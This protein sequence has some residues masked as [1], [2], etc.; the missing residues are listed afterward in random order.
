MVPIRGLFETHLIGH[1][2]EEGN[3]R[4][5]V[6][7]E[8][9]CH[10]DSSKVADDYVVAELVVVRVSDLDNAVDVGLCGSHVFLL[11]S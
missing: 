5:V 1:A 9:L 4:G 11:M 10:I 7:A 2:L 8:D 3:V 6:L